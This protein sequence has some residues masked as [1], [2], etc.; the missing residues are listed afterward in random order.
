MVHYDSELRCRMRIGQTMLD[1]F[2]VSGRP[3]LFRTFPGRRSA[4]PWAIKVEAF[5]AFR[6]ED[7]A[8][9]V[10][11]QTSDVEIEING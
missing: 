9:G 8:A 2:A 11:T 4:L 10:Y 5:Q 7:I 6:A 3:T 1:C